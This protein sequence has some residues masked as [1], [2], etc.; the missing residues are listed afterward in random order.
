L[1]SCSCW[2]ISLRRMKDKS[3]NLIIN[4][5]LCGARLD[6]ALAELLCVSR[7]RAAGLIADGDVSFG[8][9]KSC[10]KASYK[11][12]GG[13]IFSVLFSQPEIPEGLIPQ[14]IPLD[15]VYQDDDIAVINKPRGMAVHPS[16]GIPDGT[17][18][19]ACLYHIENLSGINGELRPGI[20]HRID[21]DTTGLL[22]I[23]KNDH[24]HECLSD[25]LK[26]HTVSRRYMALVH[27]TVGVEDGSIEGNIARHRTDRK[28]MA[29][30]AEGRYA[31][32]DYKVICHHGG[33]TLV[34]CSL[35][36]GRTH[37]IRVHMSHIGFPIVGDP[38]YGIKK[39]RGKGKGQL[40]HAFELSLVHP[41]SGQQMT[42]F[43]APP[44]DYIKALHSIGAQVD[45]AA[46]HILVDGVCL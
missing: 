44:A 5:K 30:S 37:Q 34:V 22:V 40:L 10:T 38:V 13:E 17:V 29:V 31:R 21:K 11:V 39:D 27:G 33:E 6:V 3:V 25:Q 9:G 4:E 45:I 7:S 14:D 16:H 46:D 42:F 43:A 8:N 36:T 2:E 32:T 35:H 41:K 19:N 24:A 28:R 20:V 12:S 23:A 1:F 15:I 26:T 18:V